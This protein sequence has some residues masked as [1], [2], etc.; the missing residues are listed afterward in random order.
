MSKLT[1]SVRLWHVVVSL[2]LVCLWG[3]FVFA[4]DTDKIVMTE[5][6]IHRIVSMTPRETL[7]VSNGSG[8]MNI[9][10][11]NIL[12]VLMDLSGKQS[13]AVL[14]TKNGGATLASNLK[15]DD[16][17]EISLKPQ[18]NIVYVTSVHKYVP[19]PGETEPGVFAFVS[20][21]NDNV[22]GAKLYKLGKIGTVTVPST[23]DA[24]GKAVPDTKVAAA[25]EKLKAGDV[26]EAEVSGTTLKGVWKYHPPVTGT[27]DKIEETDITGGK[28]WALSLTVDGAARRFLVPGMINPKGVF[29]P[30]GSLVASVKGFKTGDKVTVKFRSE[31]TGDTL[32]SITTAAQR[33]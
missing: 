23:K 31:E 22:P 9:R 16:L 15:P 12:F 4:K 2:A 5:K 26:I 14:I 19:F 10:D 7:Y 24:A 1:Q 20:A 27:V 11:P 29:V 28:T 18:L 25:L 6:T 33:P 13:A 30:N 21:V 8:G 3:G 17:V 32:R